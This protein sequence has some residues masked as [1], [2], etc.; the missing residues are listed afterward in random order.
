M[1]ERCGL[2]RIMEILV[3]LPKQQQLLDHTIGHNHKPF[4]S[5]MSSLFSVNK[6]QQQ[7]L[8]W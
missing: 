3:Y 6:K 8:L 5:S 2:F 7:L 4:S 1:F